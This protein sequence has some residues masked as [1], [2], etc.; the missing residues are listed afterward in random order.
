MLSD[1]GDVIAN[2]WY[3]EALGL[4]SL[5]TAAVVW[6]RGLANR[7]PV[8]RGLALW[9]LGRR[10]RVVLFSAPRPA[11]GQ[12]DTRRQEARRFGG[13]GLPALCAWVARRYASAM[14]VRYVAAVM[15]MA[16]AIPFMAPVPAYAGTTIFS[17][18]FSTQN[19]TLWYYRSGPGCSVSNGQLVCQTLANYNGTI[20][21]PATW[22]DTS[23]FYNFTDCAFSA[24]LIQAPSPVGNGTNETGLLVASP[25]ATRGALSTDTSPYIKV[26]DTPYQYAVAALVSYNNP[27][28][29]TLALAGYAWTP[30]MWLRLRHSSATNLIYYE[31]STNGA[32]WNTFASI[33]PWF[34]ITHVLLVIST[35]HWA[36]GNNPG[37]AIYD[38]ASLVQN[39]PVSPPRPPPPPP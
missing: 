15:G 33:A 36:P 35:G 12:S 37:P 16:I 19:N 28:P 8:G 26:G 17:D 24:Q 4:P 30:G 9:L 38:N 21:S 6:V 22:Q 25:E 39:A 14:R 5:D 11:S 31:T 23:T 20:D 3:A 18:D 27:Q 34:D 29:E 10:K 13:S 2:T 32:T 1:R 7:R